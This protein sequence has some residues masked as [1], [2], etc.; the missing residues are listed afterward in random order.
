MYER[1]IRK[2]R[3]AEK[4]KYI[5]PLPLANVNIRLDEKFSHRAK[6]DQHKHYKINAI[7][8]PFKIHSILNTA[9]LIDRKQYK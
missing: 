4:K 9:P 8:G 3:D 1:R 5:T 2:D 6:E 7:E